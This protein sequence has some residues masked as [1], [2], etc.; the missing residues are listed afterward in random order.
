MTARDNTQNDT[1]QLEENVEL[2]N[3]AGKAGL[4]LVCEHASNHIPDGFSK[5]GLD[6]EALKSHVA[7][8]P[9]ALSV[10][11]AMSAALDAPLVATTVSRLVYDC[12][13]A[14]EA[15]SAIPEKSETYNIPG[16]AGL[17]EEDRL[18]RS[19][20]YYQPFRKALTDISQMASNS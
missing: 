12:N 15:K 11:K 1:R 8:D 9:G 13:R 14:I 3:A 19:K 7:W 4:L 5:L 6:D 17:S 10:A 18:A 16:N 2:A 20:R